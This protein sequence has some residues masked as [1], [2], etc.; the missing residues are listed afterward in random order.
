MGL[1]RIGRLIWLIEINLL[2]NSKRKVRYQICY[3]N[4]NDY[5]YQEIEC[6]NCTLIVN[7]IHWPEMY[8]DED[9]YY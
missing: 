3:V 1:L 9:Y 4:E 8:D 6:L 2:R 7:D 5:Q